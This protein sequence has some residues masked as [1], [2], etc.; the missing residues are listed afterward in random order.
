MLGCVATALILFYASKYA[1]SY[2]EIHLPRV[3]A[4]EMERVQ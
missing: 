2:C 4:P 3:L 1:N